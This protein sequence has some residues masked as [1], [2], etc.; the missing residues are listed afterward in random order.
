MAERLVVIGGD[1]AGM[2][3]ATNARRGRADLEI[4]ALEKGRYTSYSACG[5]PYLVGGSVGELDDLVVRTPQEFR[6]QHRI[7]VRVGHEVKGIDLAARRLE[8][9]AL[10]QGRTFHLGFDLLHVAT[11]AR[12]VRPD[13]PGIDADWIHGVQTLTDAAGL[14]ASI[15]ARTCRRVVVIGGG[16][17]GLE[18]AEAFVDRGAQVTLVDAAPQPMR[19]VDPD[20]GAKVAEVLAGYGVTV[21]VD[22]KVQGFGDHVVHTD[23]GDLPADL[24]VLGIGVLPASQLALDAGLDAGARGAIAVDHRQRTS[25]E[26]VYAAG[27]CADTF[28]LVSRQRVHVALGTVANKTGGVAGRN[29]GGGYAS[30][31]GVLGT[32]VTRICEVEVARTGLNQQEAAAAGIECV[33]GTAEA[34]TRAGYFPGSAEVTARVLAERGTGRL[35]GGQIVGADR[36]GKRIDVLATAITAGMTANDVLELDLAY[37]PSVSPLWDPVQV[38]ARKA[39][40]ALAAAD[41]R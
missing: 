24:V 15:D 33:V 20:L 8:V 40:S 6:D 3:A 18:M 39:V 37:A 5:I 35:I 26:G 30:F 41:A 13:L 2:A 14:L 7:D 9:R 28:H 29:L 38:A 25:A 19:T 12:P 36:V 17:V 27:D 10:D 16:Y 1:A 31:P 4:V 34:T 32:A 21:Q 11:G 23:A 22:T